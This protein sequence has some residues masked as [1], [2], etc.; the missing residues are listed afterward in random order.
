MEWQTEHVI[1]SWSKWRSIGEPFVSAPETSAI[2]L[3]QPS[4]W[5]VYSIPLVSRSI[6]VFLMYQGARNALAWVVWRH[7]A[8]AS[9]WQ[10]PQ[11]FAVGKLLGSMN[12]PVSV[13]AFDGRN[14]WS[15]PKR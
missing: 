12:W 11:Y 2:G 10:W 6:L 7:C 1:P 5:R 14:G 8:Y 13:A 3:W 9:W 4:Q 15:A